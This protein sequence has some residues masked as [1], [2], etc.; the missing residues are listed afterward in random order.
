[1]SMQSLAKRAVDSLLPRSLLALYRALDLRTCGI[2]EMN[3]EW[4][5]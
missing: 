2:T 1:M 3:D 4:N 5:G